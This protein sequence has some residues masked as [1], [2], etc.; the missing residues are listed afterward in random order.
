MSPCTPY[1]DSSLGR[2]DSVTSLTRP[3]G[4]DLYEGK[5]I[6]E[7]DT[8]RVMVYS[9]G[10]W[11]IESEPVQTWSV[12]SV[13]QNGARACTTTYGWYQR[14]RGKFVAQATMS[15]F[16]AGSAGNAIIIP[17]P[18]TLVTSEAVGG[19]FSYFDSGVA[20]YSGYINPF[21]VNA[22]GFV[23]DGSNNS[24]GAVTSLA[25]AAADVM[26]VTMHGRYA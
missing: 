8:K 7:T 21:T 26:R 2:V 23:Q 14:S 4:A 22:V 19:A 9:S 15:G 3:V 16:A 5:L 20:F 25:L 13:T 10:A 11:E 12:T 24:F 17:T 1:I 18:V 6:F